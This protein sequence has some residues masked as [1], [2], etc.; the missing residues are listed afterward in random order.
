VTVS[1]D[2][3]I[4]YTTPTCPWCVRAKEFLRQQGV[5]YQERDVERDPQAARDVVQRTGQYGV[6]V[7]ADA[8]EAIVGFDVPRLRRMAARHARP[9]P[10]LGLRV[11]DAR[12]GPGAQV[13]SVRDDS[14]GARAGVQ[15]GDV[16][17]ELSGVP[18]SSVADLERI[19]AQRRPGQPTSLVVV[20]DG[21]RRTIILAG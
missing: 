19:A 18:V 4:V 3:V 14:P 17:V 8:H 7:I 10:G 9:R 15:A 20:R 13:G 1:T 12:D 21:E 6:P 16:V 5:D 11:T 2:P